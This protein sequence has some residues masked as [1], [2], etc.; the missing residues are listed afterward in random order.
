MLGRLKDWRRMA[1]HY[2]SCPKVFFSAVA[3]SEAVM[4]GYDWR[5]SPDPSNRE[6]H[7]IHLSTRM[8]ESISVKV[9][10][11]N[12][13]DKVEDEDLGPRAKLPL[14]VRFSLKGDKSCA[15]LREN[16][17]NGAPFV[18]P[19]SHPTT[20]GASSVSV[21]RTKLCS[22]LP[23]RPDMIVGIPLSAR[24]NREFLDD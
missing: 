4:F 11:E 8:K 5:T 24:D 9:T 12:Y 22:L 17:G 1:T 20:K 19:S 23:R 16:K 15:K 13:P 14:M 10:T 7:D 3:H 21:K 2:N 6:T 18:H